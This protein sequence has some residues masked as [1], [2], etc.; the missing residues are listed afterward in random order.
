MQMIEKE[1]RILKDQINQL[2]FISNE[3][4]QMLLSKVLAYFGLVLMI[5]LYLTTIW[6]YVVTYHFD[7]FGF[8]QEGK[9]YWVREL[10][11]IRTK[12]PN[13]PLLGV[14][15]LL[16]FVAVFVCLTQFSKFILVLF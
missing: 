3:H 6:T 4:L 12:N 8:E 11:R 15:V 9:H 14:F 10:E 7:M 13:Q 2:K 5:V 1:D 16:V